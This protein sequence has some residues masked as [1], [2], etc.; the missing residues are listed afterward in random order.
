[1]LQAHLYLNTCV[2]SEQNIFYIKVVSWPNRVAVMHVQ[3]SAIIYQVVRTDVHVSWRAYIPLT[4]AQNRESSMIPNVTCHM[5][6]KH[7]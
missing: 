7:T 5:T 2:S 4:Y 3:W 6:Y 1:M